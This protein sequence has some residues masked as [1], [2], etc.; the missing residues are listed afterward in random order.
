[1]WHTS[2]PVETSTGAFSLVLAYGLNEI[3]KHL[4]E[5]DEYAGLEVD[6]AYT[7][8]IERFTKMS[9]GQKAW[10]IHLVAFGL[11]DPNTPVVPL[12]AY[13]EASIAAI[14][15]QVEGLV[16]EEIYFIDDEPDGDWYDVRRAIWTV[17]EEAGRNSPD[18]IGNDE[19]LK[20]ENADIEEWEEAIHYIEFSILWDTDY[21]FSQDGK[22]SPENNAQLRDMFGIDDE[23]FS[24]IP[25]EPEP[26][27]AKK[28]VQ[29]VRELCNGIIKREEKKL[30][31]E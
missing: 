26:A 15:R 22:G 20:I 27:V 13:T 1:M 31:K 18:F 23:Y 14:F 4:E 11:L 30:R 10:I 24:T 8:D 2:E 25:E 19:P 28:L 9:L 17:H 7:S 3:V 5:C 16:Q 21:D 12:T 6:D 29:E